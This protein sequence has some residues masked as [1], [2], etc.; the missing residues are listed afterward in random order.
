MQIIVMCI[1]LVIDR[2]VS[3]YLSLVDF[4]SLR[5][6]TKVLYDD[7]QAW[8]IRAIPIPF[9]MH[10]FNA[11]KNL[12]LHYLLNCALYFSNPVGSNQWFQEM[13]D[14]LE[15][16]ISIKLIYSFIFYYRFDFFYSMNLSQLDGRR[17]FV[18]LRLTHRNSRVFKRSLLEY[19]DRYNVG[20]PCAKRLATPLQMYRN[21]QQCCR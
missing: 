13:V 11:K 7:N 10:A 8:E 14:W 21:T 5:R 17:R 18:W 3:R 9:K 4:V 1:P 19:D 20:R 6:T 2:G 12:A 16:K 15:Y